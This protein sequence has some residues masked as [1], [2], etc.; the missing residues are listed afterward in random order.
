M[1]NP[2]LSYIMAINFTGASCVWYY[3]KSTDQF[4]ARPSFTGHFGNVSSVCWDHTGNFLVS[5]SKDQTTR[6]YCQNKV[7]SLY[8]EISRAQIHGY[9]IN[10]VTLVKLK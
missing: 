2:H 8:H 6:V 4:E 7:S 5:V 9:D 1:P 3:N 10:S